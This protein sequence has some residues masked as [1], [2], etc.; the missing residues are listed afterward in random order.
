MLTAKC[1]QDIK[2]NGTHNAEWS[3]SSVSILIVFRYYF[4]KLIMDAFMF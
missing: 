3:L 2:S 4:V 1:A